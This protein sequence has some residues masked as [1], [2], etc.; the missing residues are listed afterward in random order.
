MK[1]VLVI[2]LKS[3]LNHKTVSKLYSYLQLLFDKGYLIDVEKN[4]I[5]VYKK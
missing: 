1:E 2:N 5:T 4:K 3:N